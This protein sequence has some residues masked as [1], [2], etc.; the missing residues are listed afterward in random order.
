MDSPFI[1]WILNGCGLEAGSITGGP[2]RFHEVSRRWLQTHPGLRQ[3]L[4]TTSGGEGMLRGMGC[5]LPSTLVPASLIGTREIVRALRLWSYV[6]TSLCSRRAVRLLPAAEV[7]VT[8]SDYFCDIVP[9]LHLKRRNPGCRWIA[10]IHHREL[11]PAERPGNRLVNTL[12]WKM[13]EWSL[14][15]IADR[16][17]A[18]WVYGT[19][20]GDLVKA[21]LL[22]YGMPPERIRIMQCGI[23]VAAIAEAPEP[24]KTVDA[25]MVGVRPNKGLHDILPVWEEVLRL[26]PGTTLQLMG[27]ISGAAPVLAEIERRGLDKLIWAFRHPGG[28][29]PQ[30]DYYRKLKEAR[31]LFA[32]SHEEGWGM[33]VCE[34]MAAG[35]PVAAYDLPVY[36]RIYGD[37]FA[38]V[39]CFDAAAFARAIVRLLDSPEAFVHCREAG[40]AKAAQYDWDAI[41]AADIAALEFDNAGG[42]SV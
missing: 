31:I 1:I 4:L 26:R 12:T 28:V 24:G 23:N 13:Q 22:A 10:W 18:A 7:A 15:R 40:R 39:P 38:A 14:R 29:L 42:I 30:A 3:H 32:P 37:A 19:D 21:R 8:V 11:P 20:A 17:D 5:A 16:A 6:V 25:A 36:R 33:A 9:A 35:L 41:A 34:A 2:V 27:G